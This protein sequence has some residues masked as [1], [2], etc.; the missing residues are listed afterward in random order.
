[1]N[2]SH[3]YMYTS[4]RI[5]LQWLAEDLFLI[6]TISYV[7]ICI[8]STWN[9]LNVCVRVRLEIY[10]ISAWEVLLRAVEQQKPVEG[11]QRRT[12]DIAAGKVK[13][14]RHA[15]SEGRRELN[16]W[17]GNCKPERE[18]WGGW[19]TLLCDEVHCKDRAFSPFLPEG[20]CSICGRQ[21]GEL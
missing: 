19:V 1:M 13:D 7:Y 16:S 2:I 10:V 15:W 5:S 14:W 17:L 9:A 21:S 6:R 11:E 3:P 12:E 4:Q 18:E 20:I 8:S